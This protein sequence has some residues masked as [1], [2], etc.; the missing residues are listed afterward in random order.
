MHSGAPGGP[1]VGA[2]GGPIVGK[3]ETAAADGQ[4]TMTQV[5][6]GAASGGP[7]IIQKLRVVLQSTLH[8]LHKLQNMQYQL[9]QHF[10]I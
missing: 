9:H 4:I 7:L 6:S 5:D 10:W 3:M 8:Q 1:T 2:A